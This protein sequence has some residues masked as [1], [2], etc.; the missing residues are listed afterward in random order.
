MKEQFPRIQ[1][2]LCTGNP[3]AL[4]RQRLG[5]EKFGFE[6]RWGSEQDDLLVRVMKYDFPAVPSDSLYKRVEVAYLKGYDGDYH[7][8]KLDRFPVL[9]VWLEDSYSEL[10]GVVVKVDPGPNL[11][12]LVVVNGVVELLA[13]SN[14]QIV[15]LTSS[16]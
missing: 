8:P 1:V 10:K 6:R 7:I 4:L 15:S 5:S 11:K 3:K 14:A 12:L 2:Q 9:V 16:R 13:P